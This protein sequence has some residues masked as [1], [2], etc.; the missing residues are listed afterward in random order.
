M[1]KGKTLFE[2]SVVGHFWT[3]AV[4]E[5][6]YLVWPWLVWSVPPK[7]VFRLCIVGSALALLVRIL[8]VHHWGPAFW[9][10][11]LTPT[12]SDSLLS[13]GAI[14]AF[15]YSGNRLSE[16][17]VC[18][19]AAIGF[20]LL[21]IVGLHNY[22]E[23][24]DDG[25]ELMSTIGYSGVALVCCA[26]VGAAVCRVPVLTSLFRKRSLGLL[27]KYSYGIYVY[28]VPVNFI[29]RAALRHFGVNDPLPLIAATVVTLVQAILACAIAYL[30]YQFF[31]R[32]FLFLKSRFQ[33]Q[34]RDRIDIPESA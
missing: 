13:G 9:I 29:V 16:R 30:S 6:F 34:Y 27:G 24:R 21:L 2:A 19:T 17:I 26:I 31:E 18:V 8:L 11:N 33:P 4:E 25:G 1:L 28:H 3:L 10:R 32:R 20:S 12:R 14:A 7:Y 22:H 15:L 5:Q 23:L